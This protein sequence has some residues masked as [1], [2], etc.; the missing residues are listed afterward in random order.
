MIK[1]EGLHKK[2]GDLEVL[3]GIDI[4]IRPKE[5]VCVIGPSGSGKSTFLRCL[6]KLEDF[7]AGKVIIRDEDLSHPGI[8][9]NKVR[10]HVG[11]VFQHFN[12]F[13]HMTVLDNITISPIKVL[14]IA[15]SKAEDIAEKYLGKVGLLDKATAYPDQLSGGKN[16]GLRSPEH[17]RWGRM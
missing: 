4:Q 15:K 11:M 1:V 8:D 3:K 17:L 5:V 2:Y 10:T 9:V 12:L 16:K 6:N 7:H 14:G 13:P